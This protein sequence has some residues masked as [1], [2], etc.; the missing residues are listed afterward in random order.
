[1]VTTTK[2]AVKESVVIVL[3][4]LRN[5]GPLGLIEASLLT[6][7]FVTMLRPLVAYIVSSGRSLSAAR[8]ELLRRRQVVDRTGISPSLVSL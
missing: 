1:M 6:R 5:G 8:P 3:Y 7:L 4:Q 2:N